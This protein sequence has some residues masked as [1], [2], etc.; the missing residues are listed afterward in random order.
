VDEAIEIVEF[1]YGLIELMAHLEEE[2]DR[3]RSAAGPSSPSR[4][5][6][7]EAGIVRFVSATSASSA[8]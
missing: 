7:D 4:D 3:K 1:V 5:R 8:L 6:V 2:N